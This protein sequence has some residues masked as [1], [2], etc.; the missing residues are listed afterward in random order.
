VLSDDQKR[1]HY[2][3]FGAVDGTG[4]LSGVDIA[5]ATEFFDALF[6]DLFGLARRR[7]TTGRDM[8][9][10]LEVDFE[11]AALGCEKT[12]T[13]E[14]PEDCRACFG[15]GA[16]GA[17]AGLVTCT[18]CNGEGVLRKKTGF[19]T[20]RRECM[21]C[22]GT[23][24]VPRVRCGVCEGAGLVDRE[25]SY[26]VRIPPGSIGG[27][28]QRLPREGA[29]GRRGGAAGDLHV[30]VRVRPH[31]FYG[32]EATR[33]GDVLTVDLPLTF[34]EAALGAEVEVPVLDATVKMRVPPGTQSGT[35]FRLRGKGFPRGAGRGDVHVRLAVET[36][37]RLDDD[38]RA[39]LARLAPALAASDHPR[40]R[41]LRVVLERA[42][43]NPEPARA[44]V[45]D[46]S[47]R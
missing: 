22:G 25:R 14:R 2:D 13:F 40:R 3:R 42:A 36:P 45:A 28:T 34:A 1:T 35:V 10:T 12:I 47:E 7:K 8:R 39:Q 9:Y 26:V 30:I 23:G 18:R 27:S 17:S 20:T 5:S 32:R 19:L 38:A 24:Q 15:T 33:E 41:A 11:E 29:P 4:P 6:G 37:A 46:G 21:G 44:R 43:G 16:E 31:A